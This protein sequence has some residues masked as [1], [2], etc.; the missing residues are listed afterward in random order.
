MEAQDAVQ[1]AKA[2]AAL[3]NPERIRIVTLLLSGGGSTCGDV[4]RA[5]GLSAPGV[6]Y[7]LR[8]LEEAGL[9]Q[10]S[11]RGRER[12]VELTHRLGEIVGKDVVEGLMQGGTGWH[13]T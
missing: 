13:R 12:C 3:G 9:I 10:R 2:Y 4:A 11:R 7:H 8:L 5:V 1:L 6:S